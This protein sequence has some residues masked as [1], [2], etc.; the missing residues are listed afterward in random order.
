MRIAVLALAAMAPVA[1]L[2]HHG[3]SGYDAN[4]VV[5]VKAPILESRY[6]NPHGE[7]VMEDWSRCRCWPPAC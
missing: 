5:T 2:A 1:A 6:Q 4:T 7:L 3:W